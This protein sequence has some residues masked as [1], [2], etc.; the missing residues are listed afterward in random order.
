M[1]LRRELQLFDPQIDSLGARKQPW[2]L[3]KPEEV[4]TAVVRVP[5]FPGA[6]GFGTASKGDLKRQRELT[7]SF[8]DFHEPFGGTAGAALARLFSLAGLDAFDD[9]GTLVVLE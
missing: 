3:E 1:P 7:L 4:G 6:A 8:H 5:V 2:A 9:P